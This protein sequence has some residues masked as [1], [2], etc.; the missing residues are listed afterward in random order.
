MMN[1]D[2][3][4]NTSKNNTN[5]AWNTEMERQ[6]DERTDERIKYLLHGMMVNFANFEFSYNVQGL[7][8]RDSIY[9]PT[10]STL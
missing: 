8:Y 3:T 5:H 10:V 7:L 9:F 4:L 2:S 6:R 1:S